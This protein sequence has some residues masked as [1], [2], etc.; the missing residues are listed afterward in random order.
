LY[1]ILL[2]GLL[3]NSM[4]PE[5]PATAISAKLYLLFLCLQAIAEVIEQPSV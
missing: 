5:G 2:A 1:I 4:Y 3:A